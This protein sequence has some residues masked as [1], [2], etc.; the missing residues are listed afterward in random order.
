MKGTMLKRRAGASRRCGACCGFRSKDQFELR[1]NSKNPGSLKR[2]R[3]CR[4]TVGCLMRV[5]AQ[6]RPPRIAGADQ[7]GALE[8]GRGRR[9]PAIAEAVNVSMAAVLA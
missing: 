8:H 1:R 2:G 9:V 5:E 3:F 4:P 6:A 7:A